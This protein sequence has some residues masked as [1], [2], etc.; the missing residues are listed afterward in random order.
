[1]Y[2]SRSIFLPVPV[3]VSSL[4]SDR[5][6]VSESQRFAFSPSYTLSFVPERRS[7]RQRTV[8]IVQP[9]TV[10]RSSC[11][12]IRGFRQWAG[13]TNESATPSSTEQKP[14]EQY[15]KGTDSTTPAQECDQLSSSLAR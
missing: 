7:D 13:G 9:N 15:T 4:Q 8:W 10:T 12:N 5:H 6:G 14:Y 11:L 2:T 1:M 3:F